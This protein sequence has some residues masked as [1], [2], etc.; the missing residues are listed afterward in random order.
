[1]N[2][3][4]HRYDKNKILKRLLSL[5][6]SFLSY[7]LININNQILYHGYGVVVLVTLKIRT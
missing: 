5:L 4:S 7:Y 1:M 2:Y 3:D 6:P